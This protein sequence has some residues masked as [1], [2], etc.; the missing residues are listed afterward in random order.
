MLRGIIYNLV[1]QNP[2]PHNYICFTIMPIMPIVVRP[3][4]R[5]WVRPLPCARVHHLGARILPYGPP[6]RSTVRTM[7]PQQGFSY[8]VRGPFQVCASLKLV[9]LLLCGSLSIGLDLCI[10]YFVFVL[11]LCCP[12]SLSSDEVV[13]CFHSHMTITITKQDKPHIYA[14]AEY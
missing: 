7:F 6:N 11:Y 13:P 3:S 12:A 4:A 9:C 8:I 5:S 1:Q 10:F 2:C 14:L